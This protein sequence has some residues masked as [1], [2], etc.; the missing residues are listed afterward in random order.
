MQRALDVIDLVCQRLHIGPPPQPDDD[1]I[2]TFV[3][4]GP[5]D[6]SEGLDAVAPG[7]REEAL[8]Y[9]AATAKLTSRAAQ[10][11]NWVP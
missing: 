9:C 2:V 1:G 4:V 8:F 3:Q 11:T 6:L 7:W 5:E 10:P